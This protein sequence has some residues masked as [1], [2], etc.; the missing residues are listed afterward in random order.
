MSVSG[1]E[2]DLNLAL[3]ELSTILRT[4][5]ES[6]PLV[7][8]H[9][10]EHFASCLGFS[11]KNH[12]NVSGVVRVLKH[13]LKRLGN[14]MTLNSDTLRLMAEHLKVETSRMS[15]LSSFD[16]IESVFHDNNLNIL[17]QPRDSQLCVNC[18]SKGSEIFCSGCNDRFCRPCFSWFHRK[19]NR[20]SHK[21]DQLTP[22]LFYGEC[23]HSAVVRCP[24]RYD[25]YC[26]SCYERRYL[27]SVPLD[28]REHPIRIHYS[29]QLTGNV[30]IKNSPPDR[31]IDIGSD[32]CPFYDRD[33]VLFH[34]NFKTGESI[35]R[36]PVE[37]FEDEEDVADE[38]SDV[39]QKIDNLSYAFLKSPFQ[40]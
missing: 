40:L 26:I 35:R 38:R 39:S 9:K 34:H 10:I 17:E 25:P 14:G 33:G 27:P 23:N 36:S 15:F 18:S 37:M 28:S 20:A 32:W 8:P 22:C 29:P 12:K 21:F 5:C 19:G 30:R 4:G 6:G 2:V 11:L 24:F 13:W 16:K 3:Q 1:C 7:S 31:A